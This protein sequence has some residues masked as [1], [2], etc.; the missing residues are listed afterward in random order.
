MPPGALWKKMNAQPRHDPADLKKAAITPIPGVYAWYRDGEA[1]YVGKA[2]SLSDRLGRHLGK[3]PVMTGSAFRRNVAEHLGIATAAEIKSGAYTP[4]ADD[5]K[6]VR[7]FIEG[8]RV[9]WQ[10]TATSAAAEALETAL[11]DEWQPPLTKR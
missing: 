11:K 3:G 1:I 5:V 2:N 9:A 7:T 4:T 8:C 6:A 10:T